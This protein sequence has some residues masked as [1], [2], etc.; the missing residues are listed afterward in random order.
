MLLDRLPAYLA[1]PAYPAYPGCDVLIQKIYY[2]NE[3]CNVEEGAGINGGRGTR[4][5]V[6]EVSYPGNLFY[7]G[8][9]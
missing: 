5:G 6:E 3:E 9:R 7:P 8:G 2:R 4:A 1:Y